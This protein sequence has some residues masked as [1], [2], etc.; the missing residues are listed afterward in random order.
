MLPFH[1]GENKGS[2]TTRNWNSSTARNPNICHLWEQPHRH[3]LPITAKQARNC[4][5]QL[6]ETVW[7]MWT[8]WQCYPPSPP[9][10]QEVLANLHTLC[11]YFPNHRLYQWCWRRGRQGSL[12]SKTLGKEG[13]GQLTTFDLGFPLPVFCGLWQEGDKVLQ[14]VIHVHVT[15][16]STQGYV[17]ELLVSLV[18]KALP[19]HLVMSIRGGITLT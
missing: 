1:T 19:S 6:H 9:W 10:A 12:A 2:K 8:L 3:P 14:V 18:P 11:M 15:I 13:S 5:V 17:V 4:I 16:T 7:Q